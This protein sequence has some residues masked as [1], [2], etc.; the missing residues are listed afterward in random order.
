M[1]EATRASPEQWEVALEWLRYADDDLRIAEVLLV[2]AP[3]L[4][5][6]AA[7]HC[8]Q[9]LEKM[10]KAILVAMRTEPP[11]L[12][13]IGVLGGL[14]SDSQLHLSQRISALAELTSWYVAPRYPNAVIDSIPIQAEVRSAPVQLR[15]LRKQIDSLAPKSSE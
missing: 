15:E 10:A 11:K 14:V 9:A 12:H 1:T 4:P 3:E 5:W 6:G 13:D 7:F 8:Q 2:N